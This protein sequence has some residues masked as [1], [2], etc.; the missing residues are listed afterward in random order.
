MGLV[1]FAFK[2]GQ[3]AGL[4]FGIAISSRYALKIYNLFVE[5]NVAGDAI[6]KS[7][8]V[9]YDGCEIVS[10]NLICS[11]TPE[12]GDKQLYPLVNFSLTQE[13]Q[14]PIEIEGGY[15]GEQVARFDIPMLEGK[16]RDEL[17]VTYTLQKNGIAIHVKH[18]PSGKESD[19]FVPFDPNMAALST[20]QF[21]I[22]EEPTAASG[23]EE[24]LTKGD[25]GS[26]EAPYAFGIDM[27]DGSSS[28]INHVLFKGQK[29][30]ATSQKETFYPMLDNQAGIGFSCYR[31]L[32]T[33][34][35]VIVDVDDNDG[36]VKEET[37][38]IQAER[39]GQLFL[40]FPSGVS[41]ADYMEV[42]F[43]HF[44][45][46]V[47]AHIEYPSMHAPAKDITI[48]FDGRIEK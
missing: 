22:E 45:D 41:K 17:L 2:D 3:H 32:A 7:Y 36:S 5:S 31:S 27:Y 33:S 43:T 21:G 24:K 25:G 28:R 37:N 15:L 23:N 16:A 40:P 8:H 6:T 26:S 11:N 14:F 19:T 12:H 44:G 30:P 4:S 38:S 42:T 1:K 39:L 47:V 20:D 10:I 35:D 48:Y 29:L 34:N 9:P 13:G 18:V 46:K